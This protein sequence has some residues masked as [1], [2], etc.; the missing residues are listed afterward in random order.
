[1]ETTT[2]NTEDQIMTRVANLDDQVVEQDQE[3]NYPDYSSLSH[4]KAV[5]LC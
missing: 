5:L 2:S 3:G 1:M 4:W